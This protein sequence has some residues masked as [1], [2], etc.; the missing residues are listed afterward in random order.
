[1]TFVGIGIYKGCFSGGNLEGIGRFEYL[2]G[3]VFDGDWKEMAM[4]GFE[5]GEIETWKRKAH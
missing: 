1:M 4:R 2:D 5:K 3:S